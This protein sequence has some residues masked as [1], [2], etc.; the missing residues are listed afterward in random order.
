VKPE[1]GLTRTNGHVCFCAAVWGRPDIKRAFGSE[2]WLA[3][4]K[5]L[6]T[7]LEINVEAAL[8]K[9]WRR[10]RSGNA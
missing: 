1:R 6:P 5:G 4:R 7:V 8:R 2:V 3:F 10:R 9:D